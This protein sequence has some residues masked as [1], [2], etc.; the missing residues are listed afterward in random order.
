[1]HYNITLKQIGLRKANIKAFYL[2]ICCMATSLHGEALSIENGWAIL[3]ECAKSYESSIPNQGVLEVASRFEQKVPEAITTMPSVVIRRSLGTDG[4]FFVD[5]PISRQHNQAS[6]IASGDSIRSEKLLFNGES[7][8]KLT[9]STTEDRK[10]SPDRTLV[11]GGYEPKFPGYPTGAFGSPWLATN[12]IGDEFSPL[13]QC[14]AQF[15]NRKTEFNV[16]KNSEGRPTSIQLNSILDYGSKSSDKQVLN[17]TLDPSK[18]FFLDSFS[19][20]RVITS[21]GSSAF[22]RTIN[23]SVN[24]SKEVMPG[25][26][27]PTK[28]VLAET[29]NGQNV[30][31]YSFV[32]SNVSIVPSLL[33]EGDFIVPANTLVIDKINDLKF[34]TGSTPSKLEGAIEKWV[35]QP[36]E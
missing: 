16:V 6:T 18:N 22:A 32:A 17:I 19:F 34:K 35:T 27:Y 33:A 15:A 25:F 8:F 30:L 23:A 28:G 7:A 11:I 13:G 14:L 1:M 10:G 3:K 29:V 12:L 9:S 4:A 2:A 5:I 36:A 24:D 26:W 21:N 20:E 31:T